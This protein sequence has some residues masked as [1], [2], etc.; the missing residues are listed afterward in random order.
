MYRVKEVNRK[1]IPQVGNWFYGYR[2]IDRLISYEWRSPENVIHCELDTLQEALDRIE[3]YRSKYHKPK[4]H[5][6]K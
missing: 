2:S 6:V 5:K 4:Y 3:T 1:F